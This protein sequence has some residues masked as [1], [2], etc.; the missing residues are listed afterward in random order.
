LPPNRIAVGVNSNTP[1]LTMFVATND[2]PFRKEK[3]KTKLD[4]WG[5]VIDAG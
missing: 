2:N 1:S 4:G 3:Q 5:N